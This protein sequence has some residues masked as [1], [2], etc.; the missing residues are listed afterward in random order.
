MQTQ[1][2]LNPMM[3]LDQFGARELNLAT[4][5]LRA[6]AD[7]GQGISNDLPPSFDNEGV[8]LDFNPQSGSV[9]LTNGYD[10]LILDADHGLCKWYFSPYYGQEDILPELAIR[11]LEDDYR[12][13]QPEDVEFLRDAL[14][15]DADA[16]NQYA[17]AA[18]KPILKGMTRGEVFAKA[19]AKCNKLLDEIGEEE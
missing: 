15:D 14:R 16:F 9:F 6:Y 19:L 5:L 10:A 7:A 13:D 12:T 1:H 17:P 18:S 11:L 3:T 4:A 8:Y 2:T